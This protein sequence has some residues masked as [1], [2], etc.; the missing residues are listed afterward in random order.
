VELVEMERR[1]GQALC[2]GTSCWTN[3]GADNKE[4]QVERLREAKATGAD[5]LITA[6]PKCQIH[7]RCAISDEKVGQEARIGV[8][9]LVV[10]AANAL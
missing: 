8:E 5:L 3:C 9:D 2:C 7:F 10:L 1:E 6:C 4:I